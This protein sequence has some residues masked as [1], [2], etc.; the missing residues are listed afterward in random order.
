MDVFIVQTMPAR[1]AQPG[2][3]HVYIIRTTINCISHPLCW[4]QSSPSKEARVGAESAPTT[5]PRVKRHDLI[6]QS[7]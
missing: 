5:K 3:S 6:Y 1:P 4:A 2:T 7:V